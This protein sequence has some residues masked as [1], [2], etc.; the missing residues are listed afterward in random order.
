MRDLNFAQMEPFQTFGRV[1]GCS[2]IRFCS[3]R[4]LFFDANHNHHHHHQQHQ[5]QQQQQQQH[6]QQQQQ[7]LRGFFLGGC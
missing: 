6:Q 5:Q 4:T 1:D 2:E 3:W 7:H